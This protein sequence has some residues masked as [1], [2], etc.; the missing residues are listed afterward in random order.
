MHLQMKSSDSQTY[1][2]ALLELNTSSIENAL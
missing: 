2:D 1:T